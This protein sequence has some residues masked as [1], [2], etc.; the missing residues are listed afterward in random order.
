MNVS[1]MAPMNLAYGNHDNMEAL[2]GA[3]NPDGTLCL[4][5]DG[6]IR[7]IDGL[8]TGFING[9]ISS[10]AKIKDGTP[11]KTADKYLSYAPRL[12]GVDVLATHM[13][14]REMGST[15]IHEGEDLRVM[16]NVLKTVKPRL[17]LCGHLAG[18]YKIATIGNT[19]GVR[20]DSSPA[21]Q[22]YAVITGKG[23]VVQVY[24]NNELV[25]SVDV[26][27]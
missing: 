23:T 16:E 7:V 4:A 14:P 10:K 1:A 21:E 15:F 2:E 8:R 13:A 5:K 26:F 12:A 27:F 22:H 17:F 3:R 25:D 24:H 9:I 19:V 6:E 11:R 18:P 20:V